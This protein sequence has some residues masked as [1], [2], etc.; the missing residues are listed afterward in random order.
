MM[1]RQLC[2][3][4][5]SH[6]AILPA[7]YLDKYHDRNGCLYLNDHFFIWSFIRCCRNLS[8]ITP[9]IA[10]HLDYP[11]AFLEVDFRNEEA[12]RLESLSLEINQ[13]LNCSDQYSASVS[14]LA[15]MLF[16]RSFAIPSAL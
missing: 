16:I 5:P 14:L 2:C 7:S 6:V 4:T 3:W 11:R 12:P 15:H 9:S 10:N 1:G 8:C 13:G